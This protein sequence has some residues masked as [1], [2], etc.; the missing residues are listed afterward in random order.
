MQRP[1]P[2]QR[3][4]PCR[5]FA[6][7][8]RFRPRESTDDDRQHVREHV[9]RGAAG[10]FDQRDIEIALLQ[11]TLDFCLFKRR[12]TGGLEKTL[13]RRLRTADP[14]P[15]ALFLQVGLS[16]RNAVH[17]QR[18]PPRRRERLRALI[19]QP[20]GHQPVGHHAPQIVRRLRLHPRGNFF[21][22]KFEEKFGHLLYSPPPACGGE[23]SGVGG[24]SALIAVSIAER[25][26]G[27][28]SKTSL[29]QNLKTR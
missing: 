29:F 9:Q 19:D 15:P 3:A 27:V 10:L 26:P 16:C 11:V 6:P 12:K 22:E 24:L 8:H 2:L 25:T 7:A 17:R 23:G 14:R 1:H 5:A 18:Q 13:D 28:F 20:L 4:R 21:R